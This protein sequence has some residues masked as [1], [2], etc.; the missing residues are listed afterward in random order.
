MDMRYAPR[1][2]AHDRAHSNPRGETVLPCFRL[3]AKAL[4]GVEVISRLQA[5]GTSRGIARGSS[6]QE[7][8]YDEDVS[9]APAEL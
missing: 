4:Q 7:P 1:P 8:S 3:F 9:R 2:N 6:S 5:E